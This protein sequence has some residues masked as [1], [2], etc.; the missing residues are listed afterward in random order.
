[1]QVGLVG[2]TGILASD[3]GELLLEGWDLRPRIMYVLVVLPTSREGLFVIA[4]SQSHWQTR[5]N[6]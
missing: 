1:M 5:G 6:S 2:V 4:R 3:H